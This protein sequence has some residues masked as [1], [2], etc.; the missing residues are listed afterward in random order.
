MDIVQAPN[1]S[2][3]NR[4]NAADQILADTGVPGQPARS[5]SQAPNY[6]GVVDLNL[7]WAT[8]SY[9][10]VRQAPWTRVLQ[11]QLQ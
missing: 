5:H 3:V 6:D 10:G 7:L 11:M 2:M 8:C 4:R 1:C 9:L